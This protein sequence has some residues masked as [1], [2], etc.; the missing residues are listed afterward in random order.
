[1]NMFTTSSCKAM[2]EVSE[3]LPRPSI[4]MATSKSGALT[5]W[6]ADVVKASGVPVTNE[7]VFIHATLVASSVVVRELS[8]RFGLDRHDAVG[9]DE[10]DSLYQHAVAKVGD[11]RPVDQVI[12]MYLAAH[13]ADYVNGCREM[14]S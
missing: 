14:Y 11:P 2:E 3:A 7:L 1:V 5:D 12:D 9:I 8:P 6:A 4:S 13:W 10:F